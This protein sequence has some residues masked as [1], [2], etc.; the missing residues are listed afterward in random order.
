[1]LKTILGVIWISLGLWWAIRPTALKARLKRKMNRRIRFTVFFFAL[2]FGVMVAGSVLNAQGIVAKIIGIAGLV[3]SIK[4][5]MVLTS[6]SA[7]KVLTWWGERSVIF[8]R[9]W[10]L[11]FI[12]LGAAML[13]SR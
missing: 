13:F 9:I 11:I 12:V 8:F 4:A 2:M 6:K 5:I 3:I 1:M 7:E 10:A